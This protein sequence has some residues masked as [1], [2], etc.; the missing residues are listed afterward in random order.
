MEAM[1]AR[2]KEDVVREAE[3]HAGAVVVTHETDAGAV[4]HALEPIA[5]NTHSVHTPLEMFQT[6]QVCF[7]HAF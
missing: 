3:R 7:S 1:E 5:P 6:L 2:L 4:F